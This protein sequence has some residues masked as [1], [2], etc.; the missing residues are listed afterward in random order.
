MWVAD[1]PGTLSASLGFEPCVAYAALA[2]AGTADAAAA[3]PA[4][5]SQRR[6]LASGGG[7]RSESASWEQSSTPR[8]SRSEARMVAAAR[9]FAQRTCSLGGSLEASCIA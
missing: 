9:A 2:S 5:A 7:T 3:A 8:M 1:L 6:R 4:P